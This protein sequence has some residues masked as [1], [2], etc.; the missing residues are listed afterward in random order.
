MIILIRIIQENCDT[1]IDQ[2]A[3]KSG[4][5]LDMLILFYGL[6]QVKALRTY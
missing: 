2:I 3:A 1:I 5:I 4:G 6:L